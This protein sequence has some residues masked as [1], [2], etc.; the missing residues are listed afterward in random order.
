[1]RL[2]RLLKRLVKLGAL[3]LLGLILAFAAFLGYLAISRN[4]PL[5]LPPPGGSYPVG[6]IELDWV[7]SSRPD[8]LAAKGNSPRELVVWIW[9]PAAQAGKTPAPYLPANWVQAR[10]ADQ[11]I[12]VLVESS[13]SRIRT[14]SYEGVPLAA[15]PGAFPTLVVEPGMG[16]MATDYTALAENLASNGYIVA[17]INPTGTANW[18]VFPDGRVAARSPN[19]TIPDNATPTQADADASRILAVWAQD[20]TFVMDR[21]A[22]LNADPASPFHSRLDLDHIGVWGHSFG[23]ATA[24][25]VCQKD[26]RCKAGVDMDGTPFGEER[27]APVPTPFIFLSEDYTRGCDENC[28]LMR[29]VYEHIQPG[30]GYWISVAGAGHFNFS[31]LPY[32]Q[33]PAVRPLFRLA[34]FEGSIRPERG[35][36]I[37]NAYLS[38]FFDQYLKGTEEDLLQGPSAIYPEVTFERK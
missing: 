25:A 7:D 38:A 23:G 31:D 5:Q 26:A 19:G 15:S 12:G 2:I 10:D 35:L 34:G 16:P 21:L 17:A 36:E 8:P 30:G 37:T 4:A 14:N 18:M 1:M 3:A 20:V 29:Q 24:I 28:Q 27:Q 9:Y 33:N 11:G 32:R 6:R 13:F 22:S